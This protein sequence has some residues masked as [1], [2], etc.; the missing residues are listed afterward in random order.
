MYLEYCCYRVRPFVRAPLRCFSCQQYGH[1]SAVCRKDR[2]C[3]RC[4]EERC[5]REECL[6]EEKEA[7]CLH[8]EGNHRAG[9]KQCPR[10]AKEVKVYEIRVNKK[11]SYA[12]AVKRVE[13]D[14]ME[15][16]EAEQKR[17]E[18][19]I[20]ICMDKKGFLTFIAMIINCAEQVKGK[21]EKIMMMM[22][23]ARRFLN[24]VDISAEDIEKAL[25]DEFPPTQTGVSETLK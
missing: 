11:V 10:R 5:L 21:T 17:K 16:E 14:N 13:S 12:E 7:K 4:G 9:A 1:V 22:D 8:C 6:K 19:D 3:G 23:A 15:V 24:V 18:V 2:R 20:N 25:R